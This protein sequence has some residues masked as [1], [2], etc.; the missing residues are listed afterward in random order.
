M[1]VPPLVAGFE[2]GF[3]GFDIVALLL[4][5]AAMAAVWLIPSGVAGAVLLARRTGRPLL[6]IPVG[7]VAGTLAGGGFVVAGAQLGLDIGAAFWLQAGVALLCAVRFARAPGRRA[8]VP[9][10]PP[11]PGVPVA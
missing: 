3:G 9:Q 11:V 7:W 1:S 2:L 6:A 5:F 4:I 8:P 10:V